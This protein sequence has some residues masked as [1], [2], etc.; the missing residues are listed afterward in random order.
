VVEKTSTSPTT[1]RDNQFVVR[2]L[3]PTA[4]GIKMP[5]MDATE[6]FVYTDSV[7]LDNP[8]IDVTDLAIITF[9]QD[10]DT[11]E[12]YQAFIDEFP[13]NLPDPNLITGIED[14]GYE[15]RINLFP[16]PANDVLNIQ[17]PAVV[18]SATR[19]QMI[20]S[21]G[22]AVQE[23]SFDIGEQSKTINTQGLAGGIYIVQIGTPE[24]GVARRKV[25]VVHQ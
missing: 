9:V 16:N 13:T 7:L 10:E 12:V 23:N 8:F 5:D 3:M 20:D 24:G 1:G 25:M 6:T 21:Y 15:D 22:R 19:I 2:K 18:S 11:R 14:P 17:L 4:A